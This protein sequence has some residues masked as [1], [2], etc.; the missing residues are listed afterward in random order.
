MTE[1]VFEVQKTKKKVFKLKSKR[2]GEEGKD[3]L[4]ENFKLIP[5][6]VS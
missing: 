6:R 5:N 2:K 1:F 3:S 4:H